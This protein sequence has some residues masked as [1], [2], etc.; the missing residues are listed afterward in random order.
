MVVV[1]GWTDGGGKGGD[2]SCL[3]EPESWMDELFVVCSLVL[4]PPPFDGRPILSA[5]FGGS[6]ERCSCSFRFGTGGD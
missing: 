2:G 1:D 6:V 5:F 4:S 3:K